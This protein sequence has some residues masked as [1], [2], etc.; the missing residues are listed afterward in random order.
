MKTI[1]LCAGKNGSAVLVGQVSKLPVPGEPVTLKNAR[2]VIYWAA[3]CGGLLGLA[4]QGP[5]GKTRITHAV[6]RV[7]ETVWHEWVEV[8]QEAA[9]EID[10]WP[11]C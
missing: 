11:P 6:P 5:Q 2:M 4:A 7:V 8:T 9:T 1:I 10:A 3:E